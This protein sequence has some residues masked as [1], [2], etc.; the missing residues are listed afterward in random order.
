MEYISSPTST[1][2]G[3]NNIISLVAIHYAIYM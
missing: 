1:Y 3:K 2:V